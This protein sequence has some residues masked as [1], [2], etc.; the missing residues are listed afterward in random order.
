MSGG[1]PLALRGGASTTV[2]RGGTARVECFLCAAR[3]HVPP[4]GTELDAVA[5]ESHDA[6]V[7]AATGIGHQDE[8]QKDDLYEPGLQA[9]ADSRQADWRSEALRNDWA[10]LW[11]GGPTFYRNK[12][13]AAGLSA[14]EV[15]PR[16]AIPL[17][18]KDEL[19]ADEAASPPFGTYRSVTLEDARFISTS[20][21]STGAPQLHLRTARD[22]EQ[23]YRVMRRIWWRAGLRDGDRL[24]QTWPPPPYTPSYTPTL[25]ELGIMEIATGVP[26]EVAVA[27]AHLELWDRVRPT[28]FMTTS[29]QLQLYEAAA[30]S[31]GFDFRGLTD[32]TTVLIIE[33]ACQFEGP[34]KAFAHHYGFSRL[35]NLGGASDV[36]GLVGSSCR[37]NTGIHMSADVVF[38]EVVDPSTG[39]A[40]AP[41]ERGHLVVTAIG[42]DQLWLRY[43]LEDIVVMPTEPCPCGE[44]GPRYTL[45]GREADAI[46]DAGR[47]ILPLDVQLALFDLGSPEFRMVKN[48]ESVINLEVETSNDGTDIQSLLCEEFGVS[49]SILPV[50]PGSLPRSAFKP[51]RTQ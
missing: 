22:Q 36:P 3:R 5:V 19:R 41:G 46:R 1:S 17:T 20:S 49:V 14:A 21:G 16:E 37:F 30:A 9:A 40:V 10:R 7:Q 26:T 8:W 2:P 39:K 27:A 11:D 6:H 51:R 33:A 28:A 44:T 45:L 24:T 38:L 15:P 47:V 31:Q 43:D 25:A 42:H 29:S 13:A 4:H 18:T 32:G 50:P 35:H 12:Y 34:A 48:G 23:W